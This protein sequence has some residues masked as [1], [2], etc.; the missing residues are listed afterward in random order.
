MT[1]QTR[2]QKGRVNSCRDC[3]YYQLAIVCPQYTQGVTDIEMKNRQSLGCDYFRH[4]SR[5]QISL[6]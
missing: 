3:I 2:K 5:L 1:D 4:V 6:L